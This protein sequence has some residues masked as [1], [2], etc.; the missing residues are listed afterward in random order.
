M[1]HID[2]II[3]SFFISISKKY[4]ISSQFL[5]NTSKQA[6]KNRFPTAF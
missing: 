6:T 4:L 2:N 3:I 1:R 5:H